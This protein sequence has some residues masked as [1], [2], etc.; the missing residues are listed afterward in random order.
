MLYEDDFIVTVPDKVIA[1]HIEGKDYIMASDEGEAIG[2][3]AGYYYATGKAA[4]VYI[5][6]DVFMNA[7]N[8]LT[9]L[10]IPYEIKM[11]IFISIGRQELQHKLATDLVPDIIEDLLRY[12]KSETIHFELI[13]KES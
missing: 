12:A 11:N 1:K 5:S 7:L 9:S 2:L 6:A 10:V 4:D 8:P 13:R 3:A